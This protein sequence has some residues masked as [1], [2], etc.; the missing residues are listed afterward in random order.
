MDSVPSIAQDKGGAAIVAAA[1]HHTPMYT[2]NIG[3]F[4]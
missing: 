3:Q 2:R 1:Y 4:S